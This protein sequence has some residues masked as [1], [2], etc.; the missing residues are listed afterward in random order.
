MHF[1][2]VDDDGYVVIWRGFPAHKL[3]P[4]SFEQNFDSVEH[5]PCSFCHFSEKNKYFHSDNLF[6]NYSTIFLT[7]GIFRISFVVK[8]L[9]MKMMIVIR[10]RVMA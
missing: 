3:P 9:N 1:R 6:E 2:I 5:Q 8:R 7:Q 4:K 10:G